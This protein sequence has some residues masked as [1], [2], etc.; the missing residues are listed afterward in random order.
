[1]NSISPSFGFRSFISL[2]SIFRSSSMSLIN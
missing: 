2:E 1:L